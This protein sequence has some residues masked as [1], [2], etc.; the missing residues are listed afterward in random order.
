VL[1]FLAFVSVRFPVGEHCF[2][3]FNHDVYFNTFML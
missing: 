3:S 1:Q 2:D